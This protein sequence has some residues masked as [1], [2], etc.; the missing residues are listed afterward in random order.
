MKK[1]LLILAL[2]PL[3]AVFVI[4][5]ASPFPIGAIYTEVKLPVAASSVGVRAGKVG[6]A[7]STSV[8]GIVATGDS[9]ITTAARAGG[10]T[11]ISHVDF[12]SKNILG[13]YGTYTTKVYGE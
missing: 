7:T 2:L 6:T 8:L 11:K 12:E 5:C 1:T 4:G 9:S 3:I 13:L 10:I